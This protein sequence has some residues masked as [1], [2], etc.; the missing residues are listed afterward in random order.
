MDTLYRYKN[1]A[2]GMVLVLA[3][4]VGGY[5]SGGPRHHH[6]PGP[7]PQAMYQQQGWAPRRPMPMDG[8]MMSMRWSS[9]DPRTTV[10]VVQNG[11]PY[12]VSGPVAIANPPQAMAP[13]PDPG[14]RYGLL[15]ALLVLSAMPAVVWGALA[16]NR[17]RG[18][19]IGNVEFAEPQPY[20]EFVPRRDD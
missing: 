6:R 11:D 17:R 19:S 14:P 1:A 18:N 15:F 9:S 3:G 12:Q 5:F 13:L 16:W 20:Q 10:I 4:F 8:R 7:P 2:L